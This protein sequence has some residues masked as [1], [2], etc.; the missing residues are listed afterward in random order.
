MDINDNTRTT[1]SRN[2]HFMSAAGTRTRSLWV[3]NLLKKLLD[4][5][6]H[7]LTTGDTGR[8]VHITTVNDHY[9]PV[10][11]IYFRKRTKMFIVANFRKTD[12]RNSFG[13][14]S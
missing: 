1:R 10:F 9:I 5:P 4:H 14:P 7:A 3:H 8:T 2:S 12:A 13:H 6:S 11:L